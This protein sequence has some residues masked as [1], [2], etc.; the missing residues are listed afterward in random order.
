MLNQKTLYSTTTLRAFVVAVIFAVLTPTM[1]WSQGTCSDRL[2]EAQNRY[3]E[4]KLEEVKKLLAPCVQK[5]GSFAN[6]DE[7]EQARK[8]LAK[9][10]L[11]QDD[12]PAAE[13]QMEEILKLNPLFELPEE[14][15]DAEF[16]QLFNSYK[17][18]PQISIGLKGGINYIQPLRGA[19][20]TVG[21][22][23]T[24]LTQT[25]GDLT[26]GYVNTFAPRGGIVFDYLLFDN[27]Y[28]T[29]E[30]LADIRVLQQYDIQF[31]YTDLHYVERMLYLNVPVTLKYVIFDKKF[32]AYVRAGGSFSYLIRASADITRNF[33]NSQIDPAQANVGVRSQRVL[34][35]YGPVLGAGFS[36][37]IGADKLNLEG[38]WRPGLINITDPDQRYA[39]P[40]QM[41]EFFYIHDNIFLNSL[42]FSVGYSHILYKIKKRKVKTK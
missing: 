40:E 10:Y 9:V 38:R 13:A 42:E 29:V 33:D 21:N 7:E 16:T 1:L 14:G 27:L 19:D 34:T 12:F 11:Y 25:D 2:R 32:G 18:K 31:P 22:N 28:A 39:A 41:F 30:A 35:D 37:R 8:V 5:S 23:P 20:Y 36:F 24:Y 15:D 4:G 26:A 3:D 17:V 6:K